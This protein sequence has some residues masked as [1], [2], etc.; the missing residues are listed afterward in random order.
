MTV[1][2]CR[3]QTVVLCVYGANTRDDEH[4]NIFLTGQR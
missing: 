4:Q 3:V 2:V 1:A